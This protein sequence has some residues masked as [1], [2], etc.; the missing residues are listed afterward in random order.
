MKSLLVSVVALC[1]LLSVSEANAVTLG[2]VTLGPGEYLE[3]QFVTPLEPDTGTA[4]VRVLPDA[5]CPDICSIAVYFSTKKTVSFVGNAGFGATSPITHSDSLLAWVETIGD[6]T[7]SVSAFTTVFGHDTP[8]TIELHDGPIPSGLVS[9][10]PLPAT[11][12]LFLS[13]LGLLF[14][15]GW[16]R[17]IVEWSRS[18][19]PINAV[20][21]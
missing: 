5:D 21:V 15:G 17:K 12:P 9:A 6:R 2:P 10:I 3:I 20:A 8:A 14:I 11:I 18:H 1:A 19:K 4:H 7:V 16:K 13:A